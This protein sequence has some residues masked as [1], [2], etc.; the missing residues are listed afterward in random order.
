M[1]CEGESSYQEL[2][3]GATCQWDPQCMLSKKLKMAALDTVTDPKVLMEN[4]SLRISA[5]GNV[6]KKK[7]YSESFSIAERESFQ[8]CHPID[9]TEWPRGAMLVNS[10]SELLPYY[11]AEELGLTDALLQGNAH[12]DLDYLDLEKGHGSAGCCGAKKAKP[13]AKFARRNSW[14]SSVGMGGPPDGSHAGNSGSGGGGRTAGSST[15]LTG[16]F[17]HAPLAKKGS[18]TLSLADETEVQAVIRKPLRGSQSLFS[19]RELGVLHRLV[20]VCI[21]F[22]IWPELLARF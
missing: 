10:S 16:P 2:K 4:I 11:Y 6:M 7:K 9:A 22:R 15:S 12:E 5:T 8:L 13:P 1:K 3:A 17:P 21:L 18:S 19:R 14:S 20:L